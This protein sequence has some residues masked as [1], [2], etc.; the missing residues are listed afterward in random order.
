MKS[1]GCLLVGIKTL[2]RTSFRWVNDEMKDYPL[3]APPFLCGL[4]L[5]LGSS[6]RKQFTCRHELPPA[7]IFLPLSYEDPSVRDKYNFLHIK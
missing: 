4:S 5:V 3:N 6:K 7:R 1:R 2:K